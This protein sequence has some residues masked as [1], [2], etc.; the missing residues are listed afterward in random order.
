MAVRHYDMARRN[1]SFAEERGL[2]NLAK[3]PLA[4][5]HGTVPKTTR[6]GNEVLA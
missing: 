1:T 4:S 6:P 3:R 5:G 2:A